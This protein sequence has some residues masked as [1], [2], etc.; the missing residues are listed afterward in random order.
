[1]FKKLA[2]HYY[3]KK[4]FLVNVLELNEQLQLAIFSYLSP[5][6]KFNVALLCRSMRDHIYHPC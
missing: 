6:E 5:K 1:M 2:R 4:G 3:Q